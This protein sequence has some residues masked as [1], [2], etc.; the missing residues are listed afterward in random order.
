[1]ARA[2]PAGHPHPAAAPL[3]RPNDVVLTL[4]VDD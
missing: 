4:F 3:Q 2:L 1:M